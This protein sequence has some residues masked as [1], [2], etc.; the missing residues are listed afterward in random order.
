MQKLE[1]I[2][3]KRQIISSILIILL[4]YSLRS[5]SLHELTLPIFVGLS[6]L[7]LLFLCISYS[8]LIPSLLFLS[9]TLTSVFHFLGLIP[10]LMSLIY[11]LPSFS[12]FAYYSGKRDKS[13][14]NFPKYSSLM[15]LSYILGLA[16]CFVIVYVK[17]S[18][19]IFIGISKRLMLKLNSSQDFPVYLTLMSELGFL[20]GGGISSLDV[21]TGISRYKIAVLSQA[22]EAQLPNLIYL[23]SL[24]VIFSYSIR[25][26]YFYSRLAL[27]LSPDFK[28]SKKIDVDIKNGIYGAYIRLKQPLSPNFDEFK[29]LLKSIFSRL[30][31][32]NPLGVL[33]I[34]FIASYI[35]LRFLP[36][37]GTALALINVFNLISLSF[38]SI[39]GLY[40]L[41]D[42]LSL[43]LKIKPVKIALCIVLWL[44]LSELIIILAF[45]IQRL[46]F[47]EEEDE[48]YTSR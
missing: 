32:K 10:S 17:S 14:D 1:K 31:I 19:N 27:S 11:L 26:C 35:A 23:L 47:K 43:R 20:S 18:G 9:L 7:P 28:Q 38:L 12:I 22:F 6:A 15:L 45:I 36:I 5:G 21:L 42:L 4:F 41:Y 29:K 46:K 33:G 30:G 40:A 48:N 44:I 24:Y 8:G 39:A 25:L 2:N 37:D 3:L 16:A 13:L 34:V